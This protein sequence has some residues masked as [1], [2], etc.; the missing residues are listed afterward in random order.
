MQRRA[1]C[2]HEACDLPLISCECCPENAA[3]RA[4]T[5]SRVMH[6]LELSRSW[7]AAEAAELAE[8]AL[9]FDPLPAAR[10]CVLQTASGSR[11]CR[12]LHHLECM[13]AD[14]AYVRRHGGRQLRCPLCTVQYDRVTELPVETAAEMFAALV[15]A[16]EPGLT[17]P[18]VKD[19]LKAI[20]WLDVRAVDAFVDGQ[21]AQAAGHDSVADAVELA[22]LLRMA[23]DCA[24]R[25]AD[26]APPLLVDDAGAW[27]D[28]WVHE[29]VGLTRDALVRA[30]VKTL[31]TG[32]AERDELRA[33][34]AAV[35]GLF[36]DGAEG[37]GRGAFVADDGMA[38]ALLAALAADGPAA[39][40][41]PPPPGHWLCPRCT[42]HNP[43]SAAMCAACDGPR[44][45]DAVRPMMRGDAPGCRACGGACLAAG[46]VPEGAGAPPVRC[47]R[48]RRQPPPGAAVWLCGCGGALCVRC[49][50]VAG[51]QVL[52]ANGPPR[53]P[54]PGAQA[55]HE[56]D[57]PVLDAPAAE[58]P[59]CPNC[60]RR[61]APAG[62]AVRRAQWC[63]CVA[64]A[65]GDAVSSPALAAAAAASPIGPSEVRAAP[66]HNCQRPQAPE[67][68][69][70]V[71]WRRWCQ[72]NGSFGQ[73]LRE[74]LRAR[75]H[76]RST[77]SRSAGPVLPGAQ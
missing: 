26:A 43:G 10:L 23:G 16:G 50:A 72:C 58:P 48:C 17:A 34:V 49:V 77:N 3:A 6:P 74:H 52:D 41:T 11:A 69:V 56:A 12:H 19:L 33:A 70:V 62:A 21:W 39:A 64:G 36:C 47:S 38:D 75:Q 5:R 4:P 45:P 51:G 15:P 65:E 27:Y 42:L 60:R 25:A 32:D 35:W 76:L 31:G 1:G 13:R 73:D 57:S 9:C 55:R 68:W 40:A 37:I 29:R 28:F 8:C 63:Q 54:S 30:L 46:R 59:A 67:G 20:S 22:R 18:E 14:E 66:C 44:P 7:G 61:R 24:G 71:N 2:G 53:A